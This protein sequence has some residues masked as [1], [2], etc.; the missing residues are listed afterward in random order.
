VILPSVLKQE[1]SEVLVKALVLH[2]NYDP[3]C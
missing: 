1:S 3:T 2:K